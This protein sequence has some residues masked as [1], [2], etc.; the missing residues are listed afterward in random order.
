MTHARQTCLRN[1]GEDPREVALDLRVPEADYGET[2]GPENRFPRPVVVA[3]FG[4][5]RPVDLD[6]QSGGM[7]VEVH[8]KA[9]NH[10][11]APKVNAVETVGSQ[12][13]PEDS[14]W[15]RH[16]PSQFLCPGEFDGVDAMA[17]GDVAVRRHDATPN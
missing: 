10:L 9:S 6:H 8:D 1:T 17:G 11:L 7:T 2:M 3:L 5:D 15:R 14:L 12:S 13:A 16:S 4:M